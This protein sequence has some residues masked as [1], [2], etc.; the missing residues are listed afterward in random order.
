MTPK[1]SPLSPTALEAFQ[2]NQM[3][4]LEGHAIIRCSLRECLEILQ[5]EG[6]VIEDLER[7]AD[8]CSAISTDKGN[9]IFFDAL[10]SYIPSYPA[11]P[12]A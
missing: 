8:V 7:I 9:K 3:T 1:F 2:H 5:Q 4:F 10:K 6:A 11:R 12:L